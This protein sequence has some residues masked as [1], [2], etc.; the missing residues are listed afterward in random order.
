MNPSFSCA[1]FE[2]RFLIIYSLYH[3]HPSFG[4]TVLLAKRW[5]YS[6]LIDSFLFDDIC[7]E[8]LVAHQFAN[9]IVSEAPTQPQTAFICFL[10]MLANTNWNT[11]LILLNFNNDLSREYTEKLEME[12]IST[13]SA[14]PPL[15]IITS[16]GEIGKHTIWSKSTPSVE[17]LARIILLARHTVKLIQQSIFNEFF[18]EPLFTA[19]VDGYNLII[20]LN[21]RHLRDNLVHDFSSNSKRPCRQRKPFIP[22]SDYNP[23]DS[24]LNELRSGYGHAAMFFYNPCGG[25]QIGVLW[26]PNTFIKQEFKISAAVGQVMTADNQ[27]EFSHEQLK[28]DFLILGQGLVESITDVANSLQ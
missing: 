27:L 10:Q 3:Q 5:L 13:R 6:Q 2:C 8:L 28:T 21:K 22:L 20:N 15:C 16:T 4:P 17:I 25:Q 19:S 11:E 26:K 24:Y 14:F 18:A 7:T 23:V 12:F 9:A 1:I